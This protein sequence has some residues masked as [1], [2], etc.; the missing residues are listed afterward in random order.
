M[1]NSTYYDYI[2]AGSGCAGLTLLYRILLDPALNTK[3]IL[4]ID[5]KEK[6]DNDRT[7]CFWEKGESIFQSIV[8][9]QWDKLDFFSSYHSATL[10]VSPYRYKMIRGLDFYRHVQQ[11]AAQY[12]NVEFR[13]EY[14]TELKVKGKL[15]IIKTTNNTY[16]GNYIFNST[17]IFSPARDISGSSLLMHFKGW[18]IKTGQNCFDEK[19]G[20]LMDFNVDQQSGTAFMYMLPTSK[21]EALIEYT[22]LTSETLHPEAYHTALNKY[23]NNNLQINNFSLIRE[24][25]GIIPLRRDRY[26]VHFKHKIIH[27]GTASGCVKASSGYAFEFI[28][29]QAEK[30]VEKLKIGKSPVVKCSFTNKRFLWYDRTF[31]YVLATGKMKGA[32]LMSRIIKKVATEKV[33]DFLSNRSSFLDDFNIMKSVPAKIFLPAALKQ[34]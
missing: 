18:T 12:K 31:L 23:I 6:T 22:L 9:H 14:I 28:Q 30:I 13:Y 8:Y 34:L 10:T 27:I 26:P 15:A 17:K 29:V 19:K 16:R 5:I 25:S 1:Y 21:D 20:T 2:I 7:W 32:E 3:K 24:E 11:L 33:F 4:V